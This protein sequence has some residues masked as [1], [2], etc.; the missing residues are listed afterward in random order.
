MSCRGC[1]LRSVS[2]NLEPGKA[3]RAPARFVCLPGQSQMIDVD[4]VSPRH[5]PEGYLCYKFVRVSVATPCAMQEPVLEQDPA[6]DPF[7][8][9]GSDSDQEDDS[10]SEG[11]SVASSSSGSISVSFPART[12]GALCPV[13][14]ENV[15]I[16]VEPGQ[17][18]SPT[19]KMA[20]C[21]C[22]LVI[23][24]ATTTVMCCY[25]LLRFIVLST[26]REAPDPCP[27]TL[28]THPEPYLPH[29]LSPTVRRH[30]RGRCNLPPS[31]DIFQTLLDLGPAPRSRSSSTGGNANGGGS[32][33]GGSGGSAGGSSVAIGDGLARSERSLSMPTPTEEEVRGA[34]GASVASSGAEGAGVGG[35]EDS[36][37]RPMA[38]LAVPEL[39]DDDQT[40]DELEDELEEELESAE[41]GLLN[42]ARARLSRSVR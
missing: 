15:K 4:V 40:S 27:P 12:V 9:A 21:G 14:G 36:E 35:G 2:A 38:S 42:L 13:A 18:K 30:D 33:S 11:S 8:S 5:A 6:A 29:D 24:L 1:S 20:M 32:I 25:V 17:K 22:A 39:T 7:L 28:P 41:A 26:T 37:G 34:P 16:I 31:V 10:S 19:S 3:G 23:V